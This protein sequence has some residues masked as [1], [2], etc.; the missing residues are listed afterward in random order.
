M[1]EQALLYGLFLTFLVAE[2]KCFCAEIFEV[3]YEG[4]FEHDELFRLELLFTWLCSDWFPTKIVQSIN[5]NRF[6][7]REKIYSQKKYH[8][9][10]FSKLRHQAYLNWKT[11]HWNLI[12][13]WVH[14]DFLSSTQV[15][16]FAGADNKGI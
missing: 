6:S 12:L 9:R 16:L 4:F 1:V 8:S 14:V 3:R 15:P 7:F 5:R 2:M 10:E 11:S 13:H